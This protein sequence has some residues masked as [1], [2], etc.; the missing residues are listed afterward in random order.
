M[1]H[2]KIG[3]ACLGLWTLPA[4][5]EAEEAKR[6]SLLLVTDGEGFQVITTD[7]GYEVELTSASMVAEDFQFTIAGEAHTSLLHRLSD[8]IVPIAH[9]HPG[10]F[11]GGE[12]TGELAGHFVLRFV[13]GETHEV[14]TATLLVGS[15]KSVNLTLATAT[16]QDAEETDPLL[17]HTAV[18]TGTA[19]NADT[20]VDFEVVMDSPVGRQIIGIPFEEKVSEGADHALALRLSPLDPL[21]SDTL[22]DGVDFAALDADADGQLGID[23]AA[24]DE[25]VVAAYN[26]IHRAFQ[27][28]DHFVVEPED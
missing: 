23:P 2:L 9:A 5:S 21:E 6:A 25:P 4:C 16:A 24:E 8:W 19:S 11:Q 3:I 18:V 1:R 28:H 27:S 7:L 15:Y 20:T 14:G 17:G 13:P 12:V 26:L 10:H 22:F